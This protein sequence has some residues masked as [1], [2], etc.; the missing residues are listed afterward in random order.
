MAN[1]PD[2]SLV[3]A[4]KASQERGSFTRVEL[5]MYMHL[6]PRWV[7][8]VDEGV[9]YILNKKLLKYSAELQGVPVA[10]TNVDRKDTLG[11][12]KDDS[13]YFHFNIR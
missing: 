11:Y 6:E 5:E 2:G 10:Y 7:Q 8:K 1:N 12:I 4:A 13:P 9:N 3:M